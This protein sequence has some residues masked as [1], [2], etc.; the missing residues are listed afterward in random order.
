MILLVANSGV[1]EGLN[2]EVWNPGQTA[3]EYKLAVRITNYTSQPVALNRLKVKY[4]FYYTGNDAVVPSSYGGNQTVYNAN[5]GWVATVN[6]TS[7]AIEA[8]STC[9]SSAEIGEPRLM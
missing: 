9:T 4:W 3:Q 8:I 7:V 6:A 2:L 1:A 5:G